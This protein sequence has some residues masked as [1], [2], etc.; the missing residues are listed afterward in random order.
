MAMFCEVTETCL[1]ILARR[2][3][4]EKTLK[5][6]KK[7]K[8]IIYKHLHYELKTSSYFT[9]MGIVMELICCIQ[10]EHHIYRMEVL[11]SFK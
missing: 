3:G 11:L 4:K 5:K 10:F 1:F 2:M 7:I 6:K 9:C 8:M